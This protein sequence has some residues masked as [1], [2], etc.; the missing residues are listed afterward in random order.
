MH[1]LIRPV[2]DYVLDLARSFADG[3]NAF[4]F[5]PADPTLLGLLRILT[6][7][8]LLYTHAVWG[9][10]L[11]DFFGPV[12]W[13]SPRLVHALQQGQHTYSFWWLVPANS[14]W[15]AYVVSMAIL[16]MFTVGLRTRLTSILSLVVVISYAH[17]APEAMFG[18]DQINAMLTLYLAIGPSG[19]AL[20]IDRWRA[21][22]RSGTTTPPRPSVGANLALRLINVHM[23]VIY[24]FAGLSKLQ[25]EAW[26]TGEAMWQA[27]A[28]SEYQTADMTWL[29]WHPWILNLLTH[30]CVI[31]EV[32]F[33]FLIWR[34]RLRP[35]ML[36]GAVAL[37]AGIGFCLG[38]WT[39]ALIMLVGCASFLPRSLVGD[40]L[41]AL[42]WNWS[43]R[44]SALATFSPPPRPTVA[45]FSHRERL[46]PVFIRDSV[47]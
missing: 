21:V 19:R 4:W 22:R 5:T 28:N 27:L 41:A 7:L 1:R 6:G 29:A 26:W 16:A 42:D 11:G 23:C 36:A 14:I 35:L 38:M 46:E 8:M 40:A 47:E 34:P 37:H 12:G 15:P 30:I 44:R 10:V 31:W 39:F 43:S 17:R 25:G 3:W 18:L 2:F 32:S 45:G 24:L 20:S 9:L 33:C 13:L